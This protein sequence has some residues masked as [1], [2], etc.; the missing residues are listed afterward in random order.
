MVEA[1]DPDA[2]AAAHGDI[3]DQRDRM[4]VAGKNVR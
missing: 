2:I 4:P 1:V 3:A